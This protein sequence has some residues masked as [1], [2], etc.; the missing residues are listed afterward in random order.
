MTIDELEVEVTQ[1]F[2]HFWW[3]QPVKIVERTAL[4]ITLHFHINPF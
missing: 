3:I 4:T 1:A 2:N